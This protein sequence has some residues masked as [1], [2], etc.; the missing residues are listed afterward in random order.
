MVNHDTTGTAANNTTQTTAYTGT[1]G[2]TT[3]T[4]PDQAGTT[5]SSNPTTG[6]ATWTPTYTDPAYS[7]KN[8]GNTM[9]R[10]TTTTGPLTTGFT[11]SGGGKLCI[12]DAGAS[13]TPGA[14]VRTYT[15]NASAA[16]NWTIGTDG[17]VKVLGTMCLDTTGNATTAGTLLVID[18]CN[19]DATQKWKVTSTGTLVSNANSAM[20]VTDPGASATIRTQL[21]LAT[22]GSAG[23]TWTTAGTGALPSGQTQTLTYDAEGRM[24]TVATGSG[25]HTNTSKYLYAADGSLLEQTSAVDGTDKT[26]ILYLFGGTEQITLNVSAKTWTG[27]RNI[28][29]PDGTTV[30]RSSTGSVTYQVANPQGTA[31]T[32]IDAGTLAVTRRYYDPYGNPRGTKP[33]SWVSTDENHGYLGQPTDATTGL[34]LLGARN[35]DPAQGRF[36][37]PDPLFEAGDPNQMGG[38][39]YAGDNPSTKSDPSGLFIPGDIAGG[40]SDGSSTTTTTTVTDTSSGNTGTGSTSGPP[41]NPYACARFGECGPTVNYKHDPAKI[42]V[43]LVIEPLW[44][45][46]LCGAGTFEFFGNGLTGGNPHQDACDVAGG[47]YSGG[48]D[49]GIGGVGS[50]AAGDVERGGEGV[51]DGNAAAASDS[52]N[53]VAADEANIVTAKRANAQEH[54]KEADTEATKASEPETGN[55]GTKATAAAKKPSRC[56]FSPDTPVLMDKGK[57]KPIGKIK[58]GDKVEAANPKTGKH[59]GVRTVQHVWINH[60]HD[61]LDL[62]IR[63]KDGHTAT[64][65]TTANHP[66]WNDT[67]HTWVAAG[68]LHHGDALNTAANGHAYVVRTQPTPGAANRWNLTVQQLHT[69]YVLAGATP[70][71]VHNCNVALGQKAEG[72]YSWADGEGF[73]HFGGY[74]PDAWQGPV[75]NAIRDSSVTLHVN[76]RG[77]GNFTESAKAGLQPGA[78]A[79]D[80]EMGWIAR[81]VGN[82]ERSWSSINFYRPN[83]KGA[84]ERVDVAEPDWASFGRLRPFISDAG[85]F[86]GC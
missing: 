70:V 48:L 19:S 38:Y 84:L 5:T 69:Y 77:L 17:T 11:L 78:Y 74:A 7:N 73:K 62:T 46:A 29:G 20:C 25:T 40:P 72:T 66:F 81:A 43:K 24:A 33:T 79:T 36:L 41:G 61:L 10:K 76:L 58:T 1:D 45:F 86:C 27:L 59:Q 6:T 68:K 52:V 53:E 26:R 35:Y 15:C 64:L 50:S 82:G 51:L 37:T 44:D 32:A 39:T 57:T 3:A 16:Q 18:T 14:V 8:A 23:Q 42:V 67:T 47:V 28:T 55:S 12:D 30:T 80:M 13:T 4:L 63:T 2:T 60:D 54:A 83:A 31:T 85:K 65:H 75:E 21:T 56:S 22:C 9:S 71:L 34:D 49:D